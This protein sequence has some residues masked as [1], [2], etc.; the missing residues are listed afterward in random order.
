MQILS[1]DGAKRRQFAEWSASRLGLSLAALVGQAVAVALEHLG[2]QIMTPIGTRVVRIAADTPAADALEPG[3]VVQSVD[4]SP[5]LTAAG[6]SETIRSNEPGTEVTLT[7]EAPDG[8]TR[9]VAVKLAERDGVALLGVFV[10]SH[11]EFADFPID[12]DLHIDNIGG[13]SAG[14]A[15]ALSVIDALTPEPLAGDF[16]VAATGTIRFDG[17]VGPVSGITQKARS[18]LRDGVDLFLVPNSQAELAAQVA[19]P[20]VSVIGV[21]TLD[22][23]LTALK[24][25]QR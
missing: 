3:D 2:H 25:H 8:R 6:L 18:V 19:E 20:T 9:T 5:I 12:V 11:V 4:A 21:N 15:F 22:D 24:T 23:A 16:N 10:T 14:L 17:S 1:T 13:S 7:A